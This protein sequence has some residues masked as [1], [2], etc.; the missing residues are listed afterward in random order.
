MPAFD[1]VLDVVAARVEEQAR[2]QRPD[3]DRGGDRQ[4]DASGDEN[5]GE[6]VDLH[7]TEMVGPRA[8]PK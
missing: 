5:E 7:D 3:D 8:E 1:D 4:Q 6:R 2:G